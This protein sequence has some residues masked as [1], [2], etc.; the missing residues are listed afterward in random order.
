MRL[1][2]VPTG[3]EPI[4][5]EPESYIL[6]IELRDQTELQR[7]E[8]Y[9]DFEN[10]KDIEHSGSSIRKLSTSEIADLATGMVISRTFRNNIAII[11]NAIFTVEFANMAN[12][13]TISQTDKIVL[14]TW[15]ANNMFNQSDFDNVSRSI[16]RSRVV[17]KVS[18]V[19]EELNG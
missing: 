9:L 5:Y 7:W 4:S 15:W 8:K 1:N 10:I 17:A 13:P 6:S 19:C 11:F 14:A 18:A 12:D 3:I 2:V 16:A